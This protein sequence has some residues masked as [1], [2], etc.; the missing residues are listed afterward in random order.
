MGAAP[1]H[2]P[3]N[4]GAFSFTG[5]LRLNS[6]CP[7]RPFIKFGNPG[8]KSGLAQQRRAEFPKGKGVARSI[9]ACSCVLSDRVLERKLKKGVG[10]D[11]L[12]TGNGICSLLCWFHVLGA[13]EECGGGVSWSAGGG[14]EGEGVD[15]NFKEGR[16]EFFTLG[17]QEGL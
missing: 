9:T 13:L 2:M 3:T 14:G 12:V 17:V 8:M 4:A 15:K 7:A 11:I 5:K 10:N 6:L 1:W 16:A